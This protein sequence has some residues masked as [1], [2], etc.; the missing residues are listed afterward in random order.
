MKII[1][2]LALCLTATITYAEQYTLDPPKTPIG[3]ISPTDLNAEEFNISTVDGGMSSMKINFQ[4]PVILHDI[5]FV[6][7][8]PINRRISGVCR[9]KFLVNDVPLALGGWSL[10]GTSLNEPNMNN[11]AKDRP[12]GNFAE[13]EPGVCAPVTTLVVDVVQPSKPLK[14]ALTPNDVITVEVIPM[15]TQDDSDTDC[16]ANFVVVA[17]ATMP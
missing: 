17:V 3:A 4:E 5:S 13:I 8:P 14:I 11:N 1:C 10:A 7:V 16:E 2:A 6:P 15:P 9:V 12:C